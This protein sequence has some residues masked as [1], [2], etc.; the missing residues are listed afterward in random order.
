[1]SPLKIQLLN[2]YFFSTTKTP[3]QPQ[4]NE[5]K[6]SGLLVKKLENTQQLTGYSHLRLPYNSYETSKRS[7]N[8][9]KTTTVVLKL[10]PILANHNS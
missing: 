5:R 3:G 4:T 8:V 10:E 7:T 2:R 6:A 9:P 1:M